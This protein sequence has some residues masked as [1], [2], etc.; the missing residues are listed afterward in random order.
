M[1]ATRYKPHAVSLLPVQ[2]MILDQN[3][4][5]VRH[6][7]TILLP[8]ILDPVHKLPGYTFIT[9]LISDSNIK[10]HCQPSVIG[11]LPAGNIL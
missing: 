8:D 4:Y 6:I 7:I 1:S 11:N 3:S 5:L 10:R 2:I 9:K